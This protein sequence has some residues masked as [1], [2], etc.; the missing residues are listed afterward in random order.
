MNLPSLS[1]G[2]S[3]QNADDNWLAEAAKTNPEVFSSLYDRYVLR[4]YHYMLQRTG[5]EMQAEDLTSQVFLDA[6]R[7]LPHYSPKIPFGAWLFT[8]ALRR[9]A[10]Y[11]RGERPSLPLEQG[12][13][14]PSKEED[15]ELRI[16]RTEEFNWLESQLAQLEEQDLE[17]LRL[18]YSAELS[19][20]EIG[21][22]TGRSEAAVKKAIYRL[23]DRLE[24]QK[25]ADHD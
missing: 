25:E 9:L 18:R 20:R 11:Y 5:N 14:L 22:L 16:L 3:L 1:Y 6:I 7:S 4:V 8:I 17:L 13:N 10:D 24:S 21:H 15:P 23:V 19:Y 2:A 12:S